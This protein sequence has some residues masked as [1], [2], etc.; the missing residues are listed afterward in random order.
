MSWKE[1]GRAM[2]EAAG[3]IAQGVGSAV[4]AQRLLQMDDEDAYAELNRCAR[5]LA[6]QQ[7]DQIDS[8]LLLAASNTADR[9]ARHRLVKFY[10][11]FKW[12]EADRYG[13]FAGFPVG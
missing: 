13:R 3:P 9:D 5:S 8:S 11:Y 1:I 7:V 4:L 12:A 6:T 10:A 2:A